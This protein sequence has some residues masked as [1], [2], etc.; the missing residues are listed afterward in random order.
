MRSPWPG[1]NT[2][3]CLPSFW[4][5]DFHR[6]RKLSERAETKLAVARTNFQPEPLIIRP[7]AQWYALEEFSSETEKRRKERFTEAVRDQFG[8]WHVCYS[9]HSSREELEWALQLLAPRWVVSTTPSCRAMELNYV[10]KNCFHSQLASD[11]PLWKLL[12]ISVEATPSADASTES[13]V[14][15]SMV[16][17]RT[18]SKL[19]PIKSSI[20]WEELLNLSPG[21]VPPVT[22]FGRARLGLKDSILLEERERLS[23]SHTCNELVQDSSFRMEDV[24]EFKCNKSSENTK[25]VDLDISETESEN[26]AG[27]KKQIGKRAYSPFGSSKNIS[28]NVRKMYRTMN[29]PVPRPLP[30]LVELLNDKKRAKRRFLF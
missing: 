22:L 25:E 26:S 24:H 3:K 2:C 12:D 11:D 7:S 30:S 5:K 8:V 9:M 29:V 16:E 4:L 15:S 14:C 19:R 20:T 21:K 10:K 1:R 27:T 13:S 17:T 28:E 6:Q 23:V 18:E